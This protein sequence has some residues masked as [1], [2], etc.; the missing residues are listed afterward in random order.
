MKIQSLFE[1][2]SAIQTA[3]DT[4]AQHINTSAKKIEKVLQQRSSINFT[5]DRAKILIIQEM[6]KR[7]NVS[8]QDLKQTKQQLKPTTIDIRV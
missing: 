8:V 7:L 4:A 5:A 1:Q 6:M 3:A 2:K